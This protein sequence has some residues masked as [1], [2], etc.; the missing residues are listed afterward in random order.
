MAD[1]NDTKEARNADRELRRGTDEGNGD[2]YADSI[3][4]TET[5]GIG[6]NC[7]GHVIVKPLREWH[8]LARFRHT[9]EV[10]VCS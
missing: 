5:G 6:I 4:V 10:E 2:Y 7:G 8:A 1:I 9:Q 3:F